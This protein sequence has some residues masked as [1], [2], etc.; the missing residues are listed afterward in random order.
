MKILVVDDDATTRMIAESFLSGYEVE[1]V[2]DFAEAKQVLQEIQFDVLVT[3]IV[4]PHHS[5]YELMNWVH[6]K[7]PK[8]SIILMSATK[9]C[10]EMTTEGFMGGAKTCIE[11]PLQKDELLFHIEDIARK[12]A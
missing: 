10:E 2:E 11:K 7:Y 9:G 3:D 4:L 12:A 6:S 8:T 1:A 5:G